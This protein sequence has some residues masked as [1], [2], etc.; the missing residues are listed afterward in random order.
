MENKFKKGDLVGFK[1]QHS[2]VAFLKQEIKKLTNECLFSPKEEKIKQAAKIIDY[3]FQL[4]QVYEPALQLA[5]IAGI[6]E[7]NEDCIIV[8]YQDCLR[9]VKS[10]DLIKVLNK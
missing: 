2:T 4:E 8:A 3:R 10:S 6:D 1:V 7:L 9:V 5:T